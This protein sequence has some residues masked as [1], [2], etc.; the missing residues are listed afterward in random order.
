MADQI[1]NEEQIKFY[2]ENGYLI[3]NNVL[4]NL[5]CDKYLRQIKKHANIDFA[6]IMNP[7]RFD[8]LIAQ[9]FDNTNCWFIAF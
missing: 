6:A 3:I 4:S 9:T 7:D 1:I 8:Y 5:E 2:N